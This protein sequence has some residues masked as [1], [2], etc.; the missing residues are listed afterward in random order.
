MCPAMNIIVNN[1][2]NS[3]ISIAPETV[4]RSVMV[5]VSCTSQVYLI[6]AINAS[7]NLVDKD[8]KR[9]WDY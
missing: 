4:K 1:F 3:F 5:S 6:H 8:I 7:I 9:Q 2:P